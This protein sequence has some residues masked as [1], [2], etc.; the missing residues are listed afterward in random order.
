MART[1]KMS[2]YLSPETEQEIIQRAR[3]EDMSKSGYM[4]LLIDRQL[5]AEAEDDIA[6]DVHAEQRLTKLIDDGTDE[7]TRLVREIRDIQAAWAA[8]SIVTFLLMKEDLDVNEQTVNDLFAA[9]RD[10][11]DHAGDIPTEAD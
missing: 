5:V 11:L 6:S 3:E 2:V 9:A 4:S 1:E 10:R 8:Y 7:M